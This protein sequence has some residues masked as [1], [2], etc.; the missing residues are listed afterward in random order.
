M[1]VPHAGKNDPKTARNSKK[2]TNP[3]EETGES[4]V[5]INSGRLQ[6]YG[7]AEASAPNGENGGY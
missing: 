1:R 5:Q 2:Q 6:K 7:E 3:R 4:V